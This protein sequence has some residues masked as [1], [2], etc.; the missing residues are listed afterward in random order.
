M[1][2]EAQNSTWLQGLIERP[3]GFFRSA[4]AHPV[5]DIAE[6]QHEIGAAGRCD[7]LIAAREFSAGGLAVKFWACG[8]FRLKRRDVPLG[9][10]GR[11]IAAAILEIGRENFNPI[12]SLGRLDLNHIRIRLHAEE[13][14]NLQ[15]M[16][17]TVARL[18][19]VAPLRAIDEHGQGR[20]SG[21]LGGMQGQAK[22]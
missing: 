10:A 11:R 9:V 12:A 1:V 2:F 20:V 18:V 14:E 15:R 7:F 13:G 6:G 8:G 3:E 16:P 4:V 22:A 5:M 19:G 21:R 17:V